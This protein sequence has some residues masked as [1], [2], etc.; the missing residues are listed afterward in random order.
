MFS[1]EPLDDPEVLATLHE[2]VDGF[3]YTEA[4]ASAGLVALLVAS[5]TVASNGEARRLIAQGGVAVNDE[6]VT[7]AGAPVPAAIAG[8]WL[9]V[10]IGK[11]RLRVGRLVS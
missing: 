3:T 1:A 4:D 5:G 7:E 9:V 6:R 2:A 10:R 8:E 11:K